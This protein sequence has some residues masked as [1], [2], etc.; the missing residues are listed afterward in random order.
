MKT[1]AE[2]TK[3]KHY[4][5]TNYTD[6]ENKINKQDNHYHNVSVGETEIT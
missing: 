6:K 4:Y 1:K 5:C 3:T 2:T